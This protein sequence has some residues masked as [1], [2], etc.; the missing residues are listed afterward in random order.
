MEDLRKKNEKA[1]KYLTTEK[2]NMQKRIK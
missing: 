2:K 1:E